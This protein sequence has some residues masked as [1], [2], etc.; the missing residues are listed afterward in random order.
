MS[1][2]TTAE[3]RTTLGLA[4]VYGVR[5]LGLFL[6]LPVFALYAETLA[7]AT[8][9]L[10][11][12][13]IGIYGLTQALLQIPF[14]SLSDRIGRK[15]VIYAGLALFMLGSIVAALAEHMWWVI[16][17]RALQGSGAIAAAVMALAADLTRVEQRTKA[18]AMIGMTIGASFILA[19]VMGPALSNL[20]GV[21][22]IFWLTAVLAVL[23]IVLV[24]VWVPT[25]TS[26]SLPSSHQ[27]MS[28]RLRNVLSK[29]ELLRLDYGIFSLHLV[30]TA[31]F[32]A[33]PLALRDQGIALV[34]HSWIY[35]SL[36]VISIVVMLP[37]IF[38]AERKGQVKVV[39][40][41]AVAVLMVVQLW[42]WQSL[43][44][45]WPLLVGLGF[46]FT[47]FNL[48]EATLPSLVSKVAPE[49]V[50]GIA[51]GVYSTA[52]FAGAFIGGVVGGWMHQQFG[53]SAVFLLGAVVMLSW[54]IFAFGMAKPTLKG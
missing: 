39:F 12:V 4:G 47:A 31:L 36:M 49:E 38:L 11:G 8:P 29:K 28:C 18:M 43:D 27:R 2:M 53:L 16:I 41:G 23:A 42:L 45:F 26:D 5:M 30:L 35:L 1:K 20:M 10:T 21:R 6:I 9:L 40:L 17:G 25:P 54:L 19:M 15:P 51:M 13:A 24:A 14:G 50:K 52:Q 37:F 3:Q 46:F 44:T 34:D 7:G 32:L 22:G 33:I 48:L